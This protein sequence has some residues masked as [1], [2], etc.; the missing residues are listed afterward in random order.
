MLRSLNS[1]KGQPIEASD[2]KIGGIHDFFFDEFVWMVRYLVVDTGRWLTGR[3][4]LLAPHAVS[5]IDPDNGVFV[6]LTQEQ[7]KS[8]P[9]IDTDKPV[10][11][12]R[13]IELHSH[14]AWP[15]YWAAE[16]HMLSMTPPMPTGQAGRTAP[17]DE[18]EEH[19]DPHL[20]SMRAVLGY[21]IAASDGEMGHVDDLIFE[22][23]GWHIRYL[24]VDTRNWLP[25]RKVLLAPEWKVESFSW[26]DRTLPVDLTREQIKN[27]PEFDPSKPIDRDYEVRLHEFYGRRSYWTHEEVS[28]HK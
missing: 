15:N 17:A 20:R 10:S 3:K 1:L 2:G 23:P 7:V 9:D 5:R 14:Y 21:H 4:V 19:G 22:S 25:G 27:S 8:S 28:S 16:A 24:V 26:S 6:D 11:R 12:Q 13:Q 18:N